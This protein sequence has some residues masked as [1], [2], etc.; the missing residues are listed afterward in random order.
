ME[1]LKGFQRLDSTKMTKAIAF[2][3]DVKKH[4]CFLEATA[5][6]ALPPAMNERNYFEATNERVH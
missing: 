5:Q 3:M 2:P 1:A 6:A 4:F